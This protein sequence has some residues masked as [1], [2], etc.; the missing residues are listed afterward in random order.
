MYLM[1]H[2]QN[3]CCDW[4]LLHP[5]ILM[6]MFDILFND[7]VL[8]ICSCDVAKTMAHAMTQIFLHVLS[9]TKF[10]CELLQVFQSVWKIIVIKLYIINVNI[11]ETMYLPHCI[12]AIYHLQ[13]SNLQFNRFIISVVTL[14]ANIHKIKGV[15]HKIGN[16][17]NIYYTHTAVRR[18]IRLRGAARRRCANGER[19]SEIFCWIL[20]NQNHNL[21]I[22]SLW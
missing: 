10:F 20:L 19:S 1:L 16:Y 22:T 17:E 12:I 14:L 3:H 4:L 15:C 6:S 13:M 7:I 18:R 5:T 2:M 9:T 11:Q 21:I 8:Q